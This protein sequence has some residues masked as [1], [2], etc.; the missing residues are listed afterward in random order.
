MIM[1]CFIGQFLQEFF[2]KLK[3]DKI[4]MFIEFSK[5]SG[6]EAE[7]FNSFGAIVDFSRHLRKAP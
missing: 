1:H 5:H 7:F 2:L 4:V 3:I 6:D